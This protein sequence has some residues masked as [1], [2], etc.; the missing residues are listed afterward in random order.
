MFLLERCG[1]AILGGVMPT[2][3]MFFGILVT[4]MFE[5]NDRHNLP[6]MF[7]TVVIKRQLLSKMGGF[8]LEAFHQ[9]N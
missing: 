4:I 8:W 9:S 6:S 1:S 3:S 7:V 2:I 5:D